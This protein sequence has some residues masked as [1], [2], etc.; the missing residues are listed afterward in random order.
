MESRNQLRNV[1]VP[2]VQRQEQSK[3][4][5]NSGIRM[6]NANAFLFHYRHIRRRPKKANRFCLVC[7]KGFESLAQDVGKAGPALPPDEVVD[8]TGGD[9]ARPEPHAHDHWEHRP[10][11][12]EV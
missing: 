7:S 1:E 6:F 9:E 10:E 2:G 3:I 8:G 4:R 12:G 11:S 5:P